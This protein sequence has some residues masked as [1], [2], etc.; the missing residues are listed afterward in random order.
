[1]HPCTGRFRWLSRTSNRPRHRCHGELRCTVYDQ[2]FDSSS[3]LCTNI[4]LISTTFLF[5][6]WDECWWESRGLCCSRSLRAGWLA[7]TPMP[8]CWKRRT[9]Y[10]DHFQS[11]HT[12][13]VSSPWQQQRDSLPTALTQPQQCLPSSRPSLSSFGGFL[14]PFDLAI[15]SLI[16]CAEA[17]AGWVWKKF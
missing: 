8:N 9:S 6:C 14:N 17:L 15:V 7:R 1:M 10:H 2:L 5:F 12:P 16:G 13:T 11:Q 4:V 3:C